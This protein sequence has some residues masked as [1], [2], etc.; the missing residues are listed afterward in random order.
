VVAVKKFIKY[1]RESEE[2]QN[3]LLEKGLES[4]KNIEGNPLYT[5]G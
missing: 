3:E 2:A 1:V 4:F 5:Y